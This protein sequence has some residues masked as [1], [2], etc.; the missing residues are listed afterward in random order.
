[1]YKYTYYKKKM[2]IFKP[3][4]FHVHKASQT[5]SDNLTTECPFT[6]SMK[7]QLEQQ[8]I[9]LEEKNK[10]LYTMVQQQQQFITQQ[11]KS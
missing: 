6:P 11:I 3:L 1:M 2:S 8:I 7:L 9:E 5:H 10:I 4:P